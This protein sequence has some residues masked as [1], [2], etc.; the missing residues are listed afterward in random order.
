MPDTNPSTN[1]IHV[2][3]NRKRLLELNFEHLQT[4]QMQRLSEW[5]AFSANGVISL[6]WTWQK[7]SHGFALSDEPIDCN[8]MLVDDD[9]M[10]LGPTATAEHLR[11]LIA[12]LGWER[13]LSQA[14]TTPGRHPTSSPGS[15]DRRAI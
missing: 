4:D 11:T 6:S 10:D 3:L 7:S 1:T 8:A 12:G 2:T 9:G 13:N 14:P 15:L 5:M